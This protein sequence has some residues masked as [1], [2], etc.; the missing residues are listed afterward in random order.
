MNATP[1]MNKHDLSQK[2]QLKWR[3]HALVARD[4]VSHVSTYTFRRRKLESSRF[5]EFLID[6]SSHG[7]AAVLRPLEDHAHLTEK[8]RS[9]TNQRNTNEVVERK[10]ALL[11]HMQKCVS[12]RRK[13]LIFFKTFVC[14][15]F[16]PL[17][18]SLGYHAIETCKKITP[19]S[20]KH[21]FIN[22][23]VMNAYNM[24]MPTP[25]RPTET[26]WL[27]SSAEATGQTNAQDASTEGIKTIW[28][29]KTILL[30]VYAAMGSKQC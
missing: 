24:C 3:F 23:C 30:L 20:T 29:H 21:T 9:G 2:T 18:N 13:T 5:Y 1:R 27:K 28:M 12:E 22:G 26:I 4:G 14:F 25:C 7:Y 16:P 6:S 15:D 11:W 19:K 10:S 8:N 17:N